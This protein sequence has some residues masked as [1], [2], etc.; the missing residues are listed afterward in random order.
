MNSHIILGIDETSNIDSLLKSGIRQFYF[1]FL[2]DEFYKKYNA[3]TSLNRRYYK[4]EQFTSYEKA[5]GS[6]EKIYKKNAIVY[7]ALNGF[8]LMMYTKK[9]FEAF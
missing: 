8:T 6:I 7:L 2:D 4:K 1:G 5:C 3:Q 9:Q